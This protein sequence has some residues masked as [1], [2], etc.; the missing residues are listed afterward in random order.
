MVS[1]CRA[2][3]HL[4]RP[5]ACIDRAVLF[6]DIL[7][8]PCLHDH[9]ITREWACTASA[10]AHV[11]PTQAE[12]CMVHACIE[13]IGYREPAECDSPLLMDAYRGQL[14]AWQSTCACEDLK[15]A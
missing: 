8:C 5:V 12:G 13:S 10:L 7:L 4:D 15:L 11:N 9:V 6:C 3:G 1:G 2:L 14:L